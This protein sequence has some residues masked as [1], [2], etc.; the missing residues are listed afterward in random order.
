MVVFGVIK[1]ASDKHLR[2]SSERVKNGHVWHYINADDILPT[3]REKTR[4]RNW[5]PCYATVC[6]IYDR[7]HSK[8]A[9]ARI[10]KNL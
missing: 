5:N 3:D 6:I 7:I 9:F 8:R 1:E 2:T 10:I 4:P